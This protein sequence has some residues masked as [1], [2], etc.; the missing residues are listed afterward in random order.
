M[1]LVKPA[2]VRSL[3][4]PNLSASSDQALRAWPFY[5]AGEQ[6]GKPAIHAGGRR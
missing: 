6:A 1:A 3:A 2:P 4:V 5:T